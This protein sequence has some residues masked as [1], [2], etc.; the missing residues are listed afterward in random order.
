MSSSSLCFKSSRHLP[1]HSRWITSTISTRFL[2]QISGLML[3]SFFGLRSFQFD[4]NWCVQTLSALLLLWQC[5]HVQMEKIASSHK[6]HRSP[7]IPQL[8]RMDIWLL[9]VFFRH[10]FTTQ[11]S[12]TITEL[13]G[14][15]ILPWPHARVFWT[16][17]SSFSFSLWLSFS[18]KTTL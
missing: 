10:L 2:I 11:I 5:Y 14:I 4:R 18:R 3:F 15:W 6:V 9:L 13:R 1:N 12:K 17:T 7:S 8:D 16:F